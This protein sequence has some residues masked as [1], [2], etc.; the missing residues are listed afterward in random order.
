ME[1]GIWIA[2]NTWQQWNTIAVKLDS[3]SGMDVMLEKTQE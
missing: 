3:N 2:H 1:K